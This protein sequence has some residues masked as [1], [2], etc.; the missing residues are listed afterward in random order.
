MTI[1]YDDV[2]IENVGTCDECGE[3]NILDSSIVG[4]F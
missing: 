3:E 1:H 4:V 2:E